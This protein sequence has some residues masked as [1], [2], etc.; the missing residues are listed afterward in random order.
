MEL[1]TVMGLQYLTNGTHRITH[2]FSKQL[3]SLNLPVAMMGSNFYS[4]G[5]KVLNST[6]TPQVF[7]LTGTT[8]G[9]CIYMYQAYGGIYANTILVLSH[10]L[11]AFIHEGLA[12]SCSTVSFCK[13]FMGCRQ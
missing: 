10:F 1:P 5:L 11:E 12:R 7:K 13:D 2:E 9:Q 3:T 6:P 8:M 4:L